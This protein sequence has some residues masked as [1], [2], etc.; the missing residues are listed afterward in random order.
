MFLSIAKKAR[1]RIIL[2][3]MEYT[4]LEAEKQL[5]LFRNFVFREGGLGISLG[6]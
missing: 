5:E 6:V 3:C 2:W 4:E 1:G